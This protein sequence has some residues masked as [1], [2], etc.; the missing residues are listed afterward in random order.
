V[1]VEKPLTYAV[2]EGRRVVETAARCGRVLQTGL[3]RRCGPAFR[4]ACELVRNGRI[5]RLTRVEV[6]IVGIHGAAHPT[7]AFPTA[8]VPPDVD[9]DLWL[10]P[11]PFAPFCPERILNHY[12]YHIGDYSRGFIPGNGV[13][14]VDI[15]Q[16]A[17]GDEI[18]PIEFRVHHARTPAG[19]LI[20]TVVEW[21]AEVCYRNGVRLSFSSEGR[22]HPDG[23]RF[24]GDTGWIHVGGGGQLRAGRT[25]LLRSVIG[26][27][28]SRLHAAPDPHRDFLDCIR[29]RRPPAA[30]A[31][32]GHRATTTCNA[33]E[34]AARL[35]RALRWDA[36]AERFVDDPVADRLLTQ[37]M[38]APW[39]V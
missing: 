17:I 27:G 16:W 5:G 3:Q 6:G 26:P 12:W 13:H 39:R 24:E 35:G 9:Y 15:A 8:P 7:R 18:D 10:G 11:A 36:Q 2:A 1:Y 31:A 33:V 37:P 21:H 23:I 29:T 34:I 28:E 20:D 25:D 30:C 4:H 14:Y 38:R 22:P 32:I 19:G